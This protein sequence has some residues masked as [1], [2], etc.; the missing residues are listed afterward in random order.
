VGSSF[1]GFFAAFLDNFQND[2]HAAREFSMTVHQ[3]A[4]NGPAKTLRQAR[5]EG[6]ARATRATDDALKDG[7]A[8][9]EAAFTEGQGSC[10]GTWCNCG[11]VITAICG[12]AGSVRLPLWA[13]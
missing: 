13:G 10:P 3:D 4:K 8:M 7:A 1:A 12:G 5:S 11:V 9:G 2:R 6:L